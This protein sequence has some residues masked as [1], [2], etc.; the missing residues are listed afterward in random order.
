MIYLIYHQEIYHIIR[1]TY[2]QDIYY[3]VRYII[4]QPCNGFFSSH[5]YTDGGTD[6]N[7]DKH[8]STIKVAE[9]ND[10]EMDAFLLHDLIVA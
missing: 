8:V 3:I 5:T 10:N 9:H 7:N 1:Y 2:Y 6:A 4:R